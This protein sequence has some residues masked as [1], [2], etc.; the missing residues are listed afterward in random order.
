MTMPIPRSPQ[1][2]PELSP[3]IEE[4]RLIAVRDRLAIV[5]DEV[6]GGVALRVNTPALS[7]LVATAHKLGSVGIVSPALGREPVTKTKTS[8]TVPQSEIGVVV[9]GLFKITDQTALVANISD[10]FSVDPEKLT[11]LMEDFVPPLHAVLSELAS[12]AIGSEL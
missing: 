11:R 3:S 7:L 4:R 2:A 12:A 9:D 10:D 1:S 8:I 5:S 6:L